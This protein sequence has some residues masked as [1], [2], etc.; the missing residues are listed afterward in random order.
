MKKE[1]KKAVLAGSLSI[2]L[3]GGIFSLLN[4][5]ALAVHERNVYAMPVA[6]Q[7]VMLEITDISDYDLPGEYDLIDYDV[8]DSLADDEVYDSALGRN[9]QSVIIDD[10]LFYMFDTLAQNSEYELSLHDI[11]VLVDDFM[12]EN[13]GI[14][15]DSDI[16]EFMAFF[17]EAWDDDDANVNTWNVMISGESG[18]S[19]SELH[20]LDPIL[21]FDDFDVYDY[22][23][24][25]PLFSFSIDALTG[26]FIMVEDNR[27]SVIEWSYSRA[28]QFYELNPQIDFSDSDSLRNSLNSY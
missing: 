13:F 16:H 9:R 15:L 14:A 6:T 28:G 4:S 21:F 26:E 18:V 24:N 8:V 11:I 23:A 19:S 5:E 1:T 27:N 10:S 20:P 25:F 22:L 2:G 7:P 3:L 12:Q 17:L